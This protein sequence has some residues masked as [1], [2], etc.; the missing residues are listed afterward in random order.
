MARLYKGIEIPENDEAR[1]SAVRS[2]EILETPPEQEFDDLTRLA[3]MITRSP[4]AYI[5]IFDDAR[6]WLK[7]SYGLPPNRPSRPR[8]L[9]MCAPTLC[10][11]DLLIVE[12]M[13]KVPRYANLPTVAKPPHARFYCA[14]PLINRDGF[15]LG[16]ICVWDPELKELDEDQKAAMRRLSRLTLDKLEHRRDLLELRREREET[17]N[18]LQRSRTGMARAEAVVHKLLPA[19]SAVRLLAGADVPPRDL[20]S[21]TAIS[22]GLADFPRRA[23]LL[24]SDALVEE[25]NRIFRLFDRVARDHRIAP[26][27]TAGATWLGAAGFRQETLDHGDRACRAARDILSEMSGNGDG[28]PITIGIHTGPAVAGI[29]GGDRVAFDLWGAAP[30]LAENARRKAAPGTVLATETVQRM[31]GPDLAFTPSGE[32]AKGATAIPVFRLG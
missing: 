29:A 21:V 31:V 25:L 17:A 20:A 2:Y 7:S 30:D 15:A 6:S 23:A 3:A 4:V 26:V 1:V 14:M 28:W 24:G 8:E 19:D 32:I 18:M 5:S 22:A 12:D 10:Q 16:T 9:S 27:R 13:S 11:N